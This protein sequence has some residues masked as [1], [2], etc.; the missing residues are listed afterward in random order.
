LSDTIEQG[1]RHEFASGQ[2]PEDLFSFQAITNHDGRAALSLSISEGSS[3]FAE[4]VLT[5]PQ[6]AEFARSMLAALTQVAEL[7][8]ASFAGRWLDRLKAGIVENPFKPS[9]DGS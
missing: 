4:T 8:Q 9:E 2:Y 5:L 3:V 6:L 7:E 1:A